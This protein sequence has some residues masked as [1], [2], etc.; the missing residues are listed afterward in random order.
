MCF[1][2]KWATDNFKITSLHYIRVKCLWVLLLWSG[3]LPQSFRVH[4]PRTNQQVPC[5]LRDL[6][7]IL[8]KL[9][10]HENHSFMLEEKRKLAGFSSVNH[11]AIDYIF[12]LCSF[13][14]PPSSLESTNYNHQRVLS[15]QAVFKKIN[16]CVC[17]C[18]CVYVLFFFQWREK[19][20][21][22]TKN[23]SNCLWK[24]LNTTTTAI[25][26]QPH[27]VVWQLKLFSSSTVAW[28]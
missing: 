1:T 14:H 5:A 12:F 25:I 24:V 27:H 19:K 11:S 18:V 7:Y 10:T 15:G 16:A 20:K 4:C 23:P 6:S 8:A 22:I 26:H 2:R 28:L 3:G 17:M 21:R 13:P 9:Q